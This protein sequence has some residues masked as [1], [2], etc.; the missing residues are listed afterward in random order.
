MK[1][2][3]YIVENDGEISLVEARSQAEA[4]NYVARKSIAVRYATQPELV[5]LVAGGLVLQK[6]GDEPA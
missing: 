5:T 1:T 6:A 2:R 3:Y 4:R